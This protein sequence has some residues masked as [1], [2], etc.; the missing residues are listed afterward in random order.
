MHL[1]LL[2]YIVT[3]K[4]SDFTSTARKARGKLSTA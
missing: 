4:K 3:V 1:W 2:V